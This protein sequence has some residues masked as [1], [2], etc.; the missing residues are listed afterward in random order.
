MN[1]LRFSITLLFVSAI[2][3]SGFAQS[4]K[5]KPQLK[6]QV[7]NNFSN[8]SP[9]TIKLDGHL[10][11]RFNDCIEHRVKAQDVDHL[12]EPF[13]T[14]TETRLWQ[15]EFWGKWVLG[16]IGSYKYNHDPELF[17]KI[18]DSVKEL[19]KTQIPNGYIGNY[20]DSAQLTNWD[21]WGRKYVM[22]GLLAFYDLTSDQSALEGARRVAD[23]LLS[24]VGP[25]KIDIVKTGNYRGMASSS[26]L[27]PIVK[28][29][30]K[31]NDNRYLDFANWI[32]SRW[33]TPEGPKLID[34]AMKNVPVSE[35]FSQPKVWWSWD[36]GQKAYEMMSCY[37]GLL[38]LYQVTNEPIYLQSVIKTVDSIIQ[39]EIN[40][41]GS[42]TS[43]ECWYN[44]KARQ[45]EP[46]YHTM[47][48]CV[49]IT[50]M[51]LCSSL[52]K[53]TGNPVYADQLEKTIY[54]A[55]LASM[56]DDASQISKYS[57]LEGR[58]HAGEK[59]CGMEIN[60]CNANGP[61][62][63][64]LIPEMAYFQSD[65]AIF[66]NLY[67]E[68]M[69][70]FV[71]NKGNKIS[72][73]QITDY[74]ISGRISML[75]DPT[76][77]NTF[78]IALR[79]PLWSD[80]TVVKVNGKAVSAIIH[81]SYLKLSR[82]WVKGDRIDIEFDMRGKIQIQDGYQAI[83]HGPIVLA[84]DTRLGDPL[85]DQAGIISSVKGYVNLTLIDQKPD[86][87]WMVFS[88]PV[89]LGADLEGEYRQPKNVL[90]CD[91]SSAGNDWVDNTRYRV[92]I[93]KMLN[94]MKTEYNTY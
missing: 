61:R 49:T 46:A 30:K 8:G 36:N 91:F 86:K 44:G 78:S 11:K 6:A 85:V 2:C 58:R 76:E 56:K 69:A 21:I 40:I 72:I 64:A 7:E 28:L 71:S 9:Y 67:S 84:R 19:L 70:D 47:E 25:G 82:E 92:W 32:V 13:K 22:L 73:R 17:K 29:Y 3:L 54:N 18:S 38:E 48:T 93:R 10:G 51:K 77:K 31:T 42:G 4:K 55:L 65:N 35:R 26:I 52:L 81:G 24:Q 33:E 80:S 27:E 37:E 34:N 59:Q 90:F 43:F 87:I 89:V 16:A 60:C 94:I 45:T 74:P 50:W 88:A 20:A 53:L 5:S 39:S 75:I 14:K 15:T 66:V 23:H 41:A 1:Y 63:F 62:G 79:I 68:S 83:V 12:I 57:P